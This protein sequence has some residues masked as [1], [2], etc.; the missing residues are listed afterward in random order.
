MKHFL[1]VAAM[2]CASLLSWGQQQTDVKAI[3]PMRPMAPAS[4]TADN[5][6]GTFTNP[7]FYDEFS[8]PDIIRVGEDYYLTGTTMHATPGLVILHS[9]DLVNWKFLS[10]CFDNFASIGITE[11]GFTLSEGKD[12]Y[13]QGVWAP[14]IRYHK[15]MFYVFT[16]ING[17]GL[18]VFTSENPAGPWKHT[19]MDGK[20]YDL[21]VLFDDDGKIY[22]VYKYNEVHLIELKPDL[23]GFVEGSERVIIPAGNAMGEGHHMYKVNGKYY[24][25][26]A[27]YAPVGRMQCARADKPYGPYETVVISAKETFGYMRGHGTA[28]CGFGPLPADDFQFRVSEG[29]DNYHSAVPLHQGGIVDL[30]N[31]EWWGWSMIDFHSI[32]RTTCLS[33]V[34][35]SEGWPYFGLKNNLGRTPRTWFKPNV[36]AA[37][38]SET[39]QAATGVA[40]PVKPHAAYQR[41]DDFSG[42][43]LQP[44]WQWNHDPVKKNWALKGGQLQL[45]TLPAENFMWAKNTLTQRM[46][47]P[48]SVTT[49]KL[50]ISKL[51]ENDVAGLG[52]L[53]LPYLWMGVKKQNGICT[54]NL[55]AQNPQTTTQEITPITGK[56][57]WMRIVADMDADKA[58]FSYSFDGEKYIQMGESFILS[59]QLKTFQGSRVALFAY[60]EQ[61]AEAIRKN[62]VKQGGIAL[63]DDFTVEEPQADRMKNL[64]VGKVI[65]LQNLGNGSFAWANPHGMLHSAGKDSPSWQKGG[66]YFRVHDCGQGRIALQAMN[67]T[68]FLTV[69]GAGLSADVRL[70]QEKT[71]GSL[72][73]WQDMLDGQCMLLSLKTQRYVGIDP[74]T[75]EP[76]S[77]DWTGC[78]PDRKDGT[79]FAWKAVE[80]EVKMQSE[81]SN[82]Y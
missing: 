29:Q 34:T 6:N 18:H 10:Y 33:P 82:K 48:S 37:A 53:N 64:P 78:R 74:V 20:I 73:M 27:N 19:K 41:S 3:C 17:Q 30:P 56:Q 5:G 14:C 77:A 49:V 75:G 22:A 66:C 81:V 24:I 62:R 15:G 60:N 79:V 8:D 57:V 25:I 40:A 11:P 80:G 35:W 72:F 47:G 38:S 43:T 39:A 54:F 42:K 2:L 63:F 59:Y 71:E 32:G 36:G 4:W 12:Q 52:I 76:Y 9:K 28:N 26:S 50:D 46:I 7:L 51:K 21:S 1:S 45:R 65:T 44:I 70:V 13:G 31:G 16:H 61:T 23:S 58:T 68:G 69:T 67:G 55:R